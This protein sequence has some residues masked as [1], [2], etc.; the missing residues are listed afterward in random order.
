MRTHRL[1]TVVAAL[2]ILLAAGC[3]RL[4]G[5]ATGRGWTAYRVGSLT[6]ELPEDWAAKGDATRFAAASPDGLAKV[7]AAQVDRPFASA[8]EC[9]ARAEQALARGASELERPRHHP[10]RLGER[11]AYMMEADLRGWHG[12]AWAACD[13]PRQYRLSFFGVTPMTPEAVTT[14][15]GIEASVRFDG[16]P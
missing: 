10:T 1:E 5:V 15:R 6:V 2:A 16:K 8:A 4:Q 13:G 7:E 3:G 11:A 14:Q 9:L 12:W